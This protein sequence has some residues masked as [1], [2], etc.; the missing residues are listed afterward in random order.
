ML[1]QDSVVTGAISVIGMVSIEDML[2]M[3]AEMV[4]GL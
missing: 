3:E 1:S 2:A 4:D